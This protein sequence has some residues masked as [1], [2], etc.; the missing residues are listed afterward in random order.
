MQLEALRSYLGNTRRPFSVDMRPRP[1]VAPAFPG[2]H[3]QIKTFLDAGIIVRA[4]DPVL[5]ARSER[6]CQRILMSRDFTAEKVGLVLSHI[7]DLAFIQPGLRGMINLFSLDY[8]QGVSR[9]AVGRVFKLLGQA[10]VDGRVTYFLKPDRGQKREAPDEIDDLLDQCVRFRRGEG[11]VDNP[12]AEWLKFAHQNETI[13][14]DALPRALII[15][16]A[17][18]RSYAAEGYLKAGDEM[19]GFTRAAQQV[20]MQHARK[21]RRSRFSVLP[22]YNFE[23]AHN[24]YRESLCNSTAAARIFWVLWEKDAHFRCLGKLGQAVDTMAEASFRL[25][26]SSI[27]LGLWE[28]ALKIIELEEQLTDDR[29]ERDNV[30][31]HLELST[32]TLASRCLLFGLPVEAG[33]IE[34]MAAEM[35][36]AMG[37]RER[38][39]E[40]LRF[41]SGSLVQTATFT[42]LGL[43]G[44]LRAPDSADL[45]DSASP[46]FC[47]DLLLQASGCQDDLL[48]YLNAS[49]QLDAQNEAFRQRRKIDALLRQVPT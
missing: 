25:G 34:R 7:D 15:R 35:S 47:R 17:F 9:T 27:A 4:G 30:A 19:V 45:P 5:A 46:Q 26:E 14:L 18:T 22:V 23:P 44:S 36:F 8:R 33:R 24:L 29:D 41:I 38:A 6:Y 28:S 42:I 31:R 48:A 32:R 2:I 49:G 1:F 21:D 40:G 3:R 11:G 37:G 43:R 20:V 13:A 39:I 10:P 16:S 12:V